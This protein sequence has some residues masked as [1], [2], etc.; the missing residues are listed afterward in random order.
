MYDDSVAVIIPTH[1]RWP[2]VCDAID[3]VLSQTHGRVECIVVDDASTDNTSQ[4]LQEKYGNSIRLLCNEENREKSF[5][6]NK[7]IRSAESNFVCFLDSDDVFLRD[8]I[9][10]RLAVY[11][12]SPEFNG[13]SFGV[14]R[15][16]DIS[17]EDEKE[18]FAYLA[19]R[20]PLSLD[21]YIQNKKT[22]CTNSFL[23]KKETMIQVGMYNEG[24]TN[25]EDIELFIRLL[26]QL[27][28]IF[29]GSHVGYV[30]TVASDR[31]RDQW[32]KMAKQQDVLCDKLQSNTQVVAALGNNINRIMM[33]GHSELLT[34]LYHAGQYVEFIAGY[35]AANQL[36]NT[37]KIK[38]SKYTKRYLVA[39]VLQLKQ[40]FLSRDADALINEGLLRLS[41]FGRNNKKYTSSCSEYCRSLV[42]EGNGIGGLL[43]D[44]KLDDFVSTANVIKDENNR[45]VIIGELTTGKKIFGKV[46]SEKGLYATLR[47]WLVGS[48]ALLAHHQSQNFAETGQ[49]TPVSLGF[50][51]RRIKWCYWESFHFCEFIDSAKTLVE[52]FTENKIISQQQKESLLGSLVG[53]LAM[54]HKAN[55]VHGD[56][57]LNNI[58]YADGKL[59]FVDLDSFGKASGR[60]SP[61]RDVAR[62][63]VGM[64]EVEADKKDMA[65]VFDKYCVETGVNG[66]DVLVEILPLIRRFQTKHRQKYGRKPADIF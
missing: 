37:I 46:Y 1:N 65:F 45:R 63:L 20:A 42:L 9:K 31:A 52:V 11:S 6:R 25:R 38:S 13:V 51:S 50:I 4:Y 35:R 22:I 47:R 17:D 62:L 24:L 14:C 8:S 49:A 33:E 61:I 32:Y 55:Y 57:K 21:A 44:A 15:P 58:L 60:L 12:N 43:D 30:R 18:L 28:F 64:S 59:H 27:D 48:R 39:E 7:G 36:S 16:K 19:E 2:I 29:C 53:T 5:S 34:A 23:L 41:L 66:D 40:R 26:C 56:V 10:S 54:L 3:S